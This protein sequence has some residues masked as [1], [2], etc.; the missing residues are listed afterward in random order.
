MHY[1]VQTKTKKHLN[2]HN[3]PIK[4]KQTKFYGEQN[5]KYIHNMYCKHGD[6]EYTICITNYIEQL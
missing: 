3:R 4:L 6:V 1:E 5:R 2:K